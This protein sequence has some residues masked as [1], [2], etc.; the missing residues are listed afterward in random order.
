MTSS[1]VKIQNDSVIP[2]YDYQD[3]NFIDYSY[4]RKNCDESF[5]FKLG[6]TIPEKLQSAITK[7][8]IEFLAGR[9][10]AQEALRKFGIETKSSLPVGQNR[11]PQWPNGYIGSITHTHNYAAAI[12]AKSSE[13]KSVGLD[14]EVV[15]EQSK[16]ALINHICVGD[17]FDRLCEHTSLPS[18]EVFT[19]I[20]SAKESLFK[21][22]N[23]I[24]KTFFG[25]QKACIESV[26]MASNTF[27]IKLLT[28]LNEELT[29]GLVFSGYFQKS[30]SRY[31]TVI[32]VGSQI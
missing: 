1:E 28:D 10:C 15:V 5:F 14:S 16:P 29:N 23:P 25:F 31:T 18:T 26:D 3:L 17:E 20:F 12:V 7:R 22:L 9:Y 4:D 13:W 32:L 27:T 24:S 6:L 11:A 19:F 2:L 21:A 8:R 30:E